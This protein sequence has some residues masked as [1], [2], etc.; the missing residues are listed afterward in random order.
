M[1]TAS[2]N[3]TS[4]NSVAATAGACGDEKTGTKLKLDSLNG[5]RPKGYTPEKVVPIAVK[6]GISSDEEYDEQ[7]LKD[8]PAQVRNPFSKTVCEAVLPGELSEKSIRRIAEE[9]YL[10]GAD[11]WKLQEDGE[12]EQE[13][14]K[15]TATY[16]K[17][18]F[19]KI[20]AK[21]ANPHTVWERLSGQTKF[22][23]FFHKAG[24]LG[25][26][27]A[28]TFQEFLDDKHEKEKEAL[29]KKNKHLEKEVKRLN[30][31][32]DDFYKMHK[33]HQLTA[34]AWETERNVCG[35]EIERLREKVHQLKKKRRAET[36][37]ETTAEKPAK[38]RRERPITP[39]RAVGAQFK[40]PRPSSEHA[41]GAA[42]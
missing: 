27:L 18:Q 39:R 33:V 17:K 35:R 8:L 21:G 5:Y 40:P 36:S 2:A 37:A 4:P 13:I 38:K 28:W 23:V 29:E 7:D 30:D 19:K 20:F 42:Q 12:D 25:T 22:R 34:N 24:A 41:G 31:R 11:Y 32:G 3:S 14:I 10:G 26:E 15:S 9:L 16:L 1:A 6:E